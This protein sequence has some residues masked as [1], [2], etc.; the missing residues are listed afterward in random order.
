MKQNALI[1]GN[2]E[3][4]FVDMLVCD[5]KAIWEMTDT[6]WLKETFCH[7][8]G[9]KKKDAGMPFHEKKVLIKEETSLKKY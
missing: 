9:C 2:D 3:V 4:K 1:W 6:G 7:F 8:C 5:M